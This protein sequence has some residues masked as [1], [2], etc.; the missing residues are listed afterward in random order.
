MGGA[1]RYPSRSGEAMGFARAQP[2]IRAN[3]GATL[4]QPYCVFS[5]IFKTNMWAAVT[6]TEK[7]TIPSSAPCTFCGV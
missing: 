5:A 1:K 3:D 2:I 7:S 4:L 6:I